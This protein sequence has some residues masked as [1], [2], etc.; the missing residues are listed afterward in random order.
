MRYR[1]IEYALDVK[2]LDE[3]GRTLNQPYVLKIRCCAGV[4]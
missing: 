3:V 2:K 1:L 4:S